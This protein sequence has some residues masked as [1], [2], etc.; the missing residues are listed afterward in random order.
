[1]GVQSSLKRDG[2][3]EIERLDERR[4]ESF[5][6]LGTSRSQASACGPTAL[7]PALPSEWLD[8]QTDRL[9]DSQGEHLA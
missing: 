9:K 1:M 5:E 7:A 6:T 8:T 2:D 4:E 3:E